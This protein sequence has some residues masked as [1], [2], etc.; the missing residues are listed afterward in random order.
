MNLEVKSNPIAQLELLK[1]FTFTDKL[2]F[3]DELIQNASRAKAKSVTI[4][5][6]S[7]SVT[8]KNDGVVLGDPQS[9]FSIAESNWDSSVNDENPFGIGF[10]SVVAAFNTI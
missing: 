9:L 2:V 10:F 8:I 6:D 5:A 7:Q 4:E 1:Q 3:L